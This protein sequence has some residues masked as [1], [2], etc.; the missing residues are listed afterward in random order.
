MKRLSALMVPLLLLAFALFA[1]PADAASGKPVKIIFDTDMGNDVDDALALAILHAGIARAEGELLAV[2]VTKS[3]AAAAKY[4]QMV[5]AF[6]GHPDIP[7][8]LVENGVTP[9]DGKYVKKVLEDAAKRTEPWTKRWNKELPVENAVTLLRKTLAAAEDHSVVIAQ[10]GFSTNLA[11]LLDTPGDAVSPLTGKELAEKKV[12]YLSAMAGGFTEQYKKHREYNVVTD[13][14]AAQKLF[15]EWPTPIL[16]SGYEI[17]PVIPMTGLAMRNDYGYAAWH[18]I[19]ESYRYY[20]DGLDKEQWTWDLTCALEALRPDRNYFTMSDPGKVTVRDDGTT[21]FT[22]AA[23]GKHRLFKEV[24]P[25]QIARV[26]E[27]FFYLCS[28]PPHK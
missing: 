16:V 5:N 20:R 10:V 4:I 17:G 25:E 18:P 23:D 9:D 19:Q 28:E 22:P 7:V 11:R 13:V 12:K 21:F 2:T 24:T 27:A 26:Q 6:Y 1:S 15:A 8:G 14:S 3:N